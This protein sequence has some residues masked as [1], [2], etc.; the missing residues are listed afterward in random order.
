MLLYDGGRVLVT[1]AAG[2]VLGFLYVLLLPVAWIIAATVILMQRLVAGLA[3]VA[4]RS[5]AFGWRPRE[6]YLTGKKKK[7]KADKE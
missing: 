2:S 6:A 4:A 7:K 3:G 1:M 5:T